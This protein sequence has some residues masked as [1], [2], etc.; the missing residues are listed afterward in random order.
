[1]AMHVKNR[2]PKLDDVTQR[3]GWATAEV[4]ALVDG[5]L[6][7]DPARRFPSAEVMMQALDDAFYSIDHLDD[8]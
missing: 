6:I 5:A 2:V 3:A 8:V 1:M 4:C 7:K